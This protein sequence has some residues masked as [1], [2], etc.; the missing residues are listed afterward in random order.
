MN[1]AQED[2]FLLSNTGLSKQICGILCPFVRSRP[3][4]AARLLIGCDLFRRMMQLQSCLCAALSTMDIS[5]F[6]VIVEYALWKGSCGTLSVG[7]I[8]L[9]LSRNPHNSTSSSALELVW[10]DLSCFLIVFT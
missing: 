7:F 5:L 9:P 8:N 1:R 6:I 2:V 10:I 3:F 4:F